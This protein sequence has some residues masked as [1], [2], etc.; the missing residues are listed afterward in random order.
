MNV[1]FLQQVTAPVAELLSELNWDLR[2]APV[3]DCFV[4]VTRPEGLVL[5]GLLGAPATPRRSQPRTHRLCGPG[6]CSDCCWIMIEIRCAS[7][8]SCCNAPFHW[9]CW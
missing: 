5:V 6:I 7:T 4:E 9:S 8:R 3:T 2:I 1:A